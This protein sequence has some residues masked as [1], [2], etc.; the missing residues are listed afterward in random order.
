MEGK[1]REGKARQGKA[2]FFLPHDPHEAAKRTTLYVGC[3][4][5]PNEPFVFVFLREIQGIQKKISIL[6]GEFPSSCFDFF[7]TLGDSRV[8]FF[9]VNCCQGYDV[10]DVTYLRFIELGLKQRINY[11]CLL[12]LV[13]NDTIESIELNAL[14]L[15]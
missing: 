8:S 9:F 14:R 1:G 12:T 2:S 10:H 5:L 13:I 4:V 7:R 15:Y 3:T 11:I 6:N